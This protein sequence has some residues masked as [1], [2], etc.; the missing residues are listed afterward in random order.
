M[1]LPQGLYQLLFFTPE[2]LI[3]NKRWGLVIEKDAYTESLEAFVIDEAHCV[4][5]GKSQ[6]MLPAGTQLLSQNLHCHCWGY[7]FHFVLKWIGEVCSLIL[8]RVS[9]MALTATAMKRDRPV[10][11]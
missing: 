10:N 11:H 6:V 8:S 1:D 5:H 4:K 7:T 3:T 2:M 9:E